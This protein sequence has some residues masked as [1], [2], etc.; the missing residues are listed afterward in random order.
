MSV[1]LSFVASFLI[2]LRQCVESTIRAAVMAPRPRPVVLAAVLFLATTGVATARWVMPMEGYVWV[3]FDPDG[4]TYA[5][6]SNVFSVNVFICNTSGTG[7]IGLHEIQSITIGT[8]PWDGGSMLEDLTSA[9]NVGYTGSDEECG[10][11][12]EGTAEF[13]S[14][15]V[16]Q[17]LQ[18]KRLYAYVEQDDGEFYPPLVDEAYS[19]VFE[20]PRLPV[21]DTALVKPLAM[22]ASGCAASCFDV[23]ASYTTPAYMSLDA[24]RAVTLLYSSQQAQA[25]HTVIMMVADTTEEL[26]MGRVGI[27]LKKPNDSYVTFVN[28]STEMV[29][30]GNDVS[31]LHGVQFEEELLTGAYEYTAEMKY[32]WTG[33]GDTIVAGTSAPARVLVLN[34]RDSPY[35]AGWG[36]AGL[37][38]V[39]TLTVG[40]SVVLSGGDGSVGYFEWTGSGYDSPPGDFSTL[41]YRGSPD[42]IRYERR[43]PDSTKAYFR[44]DGRLSYIEDR[45]GNRNAYRYNGSGALTR[46]TDPAGLAINLA[47]TSN[48][49]DS[50]TDAAGRTTQITIDSV[51][52]LIEIQDPAG[53]KPLQE[54]VYSHHRLTS[55]T[56]RRGNTWKYTYDF[57][58]KIATDSTPAVT[59]GG[60]TG[61]LGT[62]H[63]SPYR[64]YLADPAIEYGT[65]ASPASG[66]IWLAS[67][68]G[69]GIVVGPAGDTTIVSPD[70]FGAPVFVKYR[71]GDS[72]VTARD[73][74]NRVTREVTSSTARTY[75]WSGTRLLSDSNEV[76][77]EVRK[78]Y[79][80][81]SYPD[82]VT[83]DSGRITVLSYYS[84]PGRLDSTKTQGEGATKFTH[85]GRGRPTLTISP[86]AD[87]TR[88]H[89][90]S[91]TWLN[92]DSVVTGTRR[93]ATT[94]DA[95]GRVATQKNPVNHA[96]S[97]FY[98]VLNRVTRSAGALGHTLTYA[99]DDSL[100]LTR[101]TDANLN[102]QRYEKNAVGWDTA[103]VDARGKRE[104]LTYTKRGQVT[105]WINRRG[106]T[107]TVGYDSQGRENIATL[108]DGRVNTYGYG[109]SGAFERWRWASNAQGSDTIRTKGDTTWEIS[110]RGGVKYQSLTVYD[111]STHDRVATVSR[112]GTG[113]WDRSVTYDYD[114][115]GTLKRIVEP[116]NVATIVGY[117]NNRIAAIALPFGDTL[118]RAYRPTHSLAR[119]SHTA[120][121]INASQGASYNDN[122]LSRAV[123][124]LTAGRD[125]V[126]RFEYDDRERLLARRRHTLTSA[127][128]ADTTSEFGTLCYTGTGT[129]IDSLLYSYDAV[130]NRTDRGA[131]TDTGNRLVRFDGDTLIYDDAG[132]LVHR[133]R[134][135]D[136]T[137]FEQ[138]LAWNSIGQL[139]TVHT[140]RGGD[141][142]VVIYGYDGFGRRASRRAILETGGA[143]TRFLHR[144]Q[145]VVAEFDSAGNLGKTYTYYAGT[146][147][148]HGMQLG[149]GVRYYFASDGKQQVTGIVDS[150]GVLVATYRYTPWGS[151][152]SATG[153][154]SNSIRFGGREYDAE[155]GLYYNRAR[156]YDPQIGRFISEDPIGPRGGVNLYAYGNND[157]VNSRDPSG[158]CPIPANTCP[159][160]FWVGL[161]S[162]MGAAGGLAVAASCTAGSGGICLLATPYIVGNFM[163]LGAAVGATIQVM[164]NSGSITSS[165]GPSFS[166]N[167]VDDDGELWV[168]D[169]DKVHGNLPDPIPEE[170]EEWE[171]ENWIQLTKTSIRVRK[172]ENGG[173]LDGNHRIR[174]NNE[175]KFIKRLEERKQQM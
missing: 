39:H 7:D 65:W 3:G 147:R 103:K 139:D 167:E 69:K 124:R 152:E 71:T 30:A 28:D 91:T 35:G 2:R 163:M 29:F 116:N 159:P 155:T 47:Y 46:V 164:A 54:M 144:R 34:E 40:S 138:A 130:G 44:G 58:G 37:Q 135:G 70:R 81:A 22:H 119:L 52:N 85:D 93:S 16:A 86:N 96:D 56:D 104:Y 149:S 134:I 76:T 12:Y 117:S 77:G 64:D 36:I 122:A 102:A 60:V 48:M 62:T 166:D 170:W 55:K 61:R 45:F 126:D 113:G 17:S 43:Y 165:W 41:H 59:A 150:S 84:P 174:V 129:R 33:W 100:N 24:P 120:G 87:T 83:R 169:D 42:T 68:Y 53:G 172:A 1:D 137:Q 18:A 49:L 99:Y 151:L 145:Q 90:D 133:Y 15:S 63:K 50:I 153:S 161:G 38:R 67:R 168:G 8:V 26:T 73:D 82:L 25:L 175:E 98:D 23:T 13:S 74:S 66:Y 140:V 106:D 6:N 88:Y 89:R 146:D 11:I 51:G 121:T 80:H 95:Y 19:G 162:A 20:G 112:A 128:A 156:Y 14:F 171:I 132:N 79:Y 115:T 118:R 78:F 127:C 32:E 4:G 143:F 141:T 105:R 10:E 5:E 92:T 111:S 154:L 131:A 27:R 142:S 72:V 173:R 108:A 148:P 9:F 160:G 31:T 97:T 107:T 136:P 75:K 157:P 21:F 110:I 114:S 158:L 94:Y 57:A 109:S 123:E 125:T 101:I